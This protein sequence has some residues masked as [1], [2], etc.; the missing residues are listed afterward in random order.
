MQ[1]NPPDNP[2]KPINNLFKILLL[3]LRLKIELP[4]KFAIYNID[5]LHDF[6]IHL[7]DYINCTD[8]YDLKYFITK[9]HGFKDR[10]KNFNERYIII[11]LNISLN[12]LKKNLMNLT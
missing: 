5:K 3:L 1:I 8:S 2:T 11:P 7:R 9:M 4:L 6:T 10:L 12:A